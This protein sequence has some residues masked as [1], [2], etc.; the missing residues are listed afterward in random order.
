MSAAPFITSHE[1][2]IFGSQLHVEPKTGLDGFLLSCSS[3]PAVKSRSSNSSDDLAGLCHEARQNP[4]QCFELPSSL[5]EK[6][7]SYSL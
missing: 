6:S 7:I 5:A 4:S 1:E 2:V 3:V